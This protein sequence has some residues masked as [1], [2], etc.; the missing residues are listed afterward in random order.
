MYVHNDPINFLDPSGL[1][2]TGTGLITSFATGATITGIGGGM[3]LGPGGAI[4]GVFIGGSAGMLKYVVMDYLG[5]T[6]QQI[7]DKYKEQIDK[8]GAVRPPENYKDS[9]H[10]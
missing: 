10:K 7:Y 2:V 3:A 5:I 4:A 6:P 8:T 9:C 1:E